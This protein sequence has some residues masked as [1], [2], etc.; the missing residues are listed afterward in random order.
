MPASPITT[1]L[2]DWLDG[3][4]KELFARTR[5]GRSE[6]LRRIVEEW[7]AMDRFSEIEFREGVSGRR[8]SVRGGPDVWEIMMV[9]EDYGDDL[10]GL[11][12]H[13][14]WL[15]REKLDHALA[16]AATF[17]DQIRHELELNE[18]VGRMLE[19]RAREARPQIRKAG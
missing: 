11:R 3:D 19:A 12:A 2:P 1:R 6:G 15:P 5:E 13:F 14:E 17:P 18:R 8:A 10:A 16:Y 7:W 9:A 4:L